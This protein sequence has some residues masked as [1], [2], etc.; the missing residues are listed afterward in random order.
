MLSTIITITDYT[1]EVKIR[2]LH[3]QVLFHLISLCSFDNEKS[4]ESHTQANVR[5]GHKS[6]S[7]LFRFTHKNQSVC[8]PDSPIHSLSFMSAASFESH[9][10][11]RD[12]NIKN[13][14]PRLFSNCRCGESEIRTHGTLASPPVFKTGALNHSAI[15]PN[16][17]TSFKFVVPGNDGFMVSALTL[18]VEKYEAVH[19]SPTQ[20]SL[21]IFS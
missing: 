13:S 9:S 8:D 14:H 15:S 2:R 5:F 11:K 1:R 6:L 10:L 18:F 3:R 4:F 7:F 16:I 12:A 17:F 20:P 19:I 21:Q